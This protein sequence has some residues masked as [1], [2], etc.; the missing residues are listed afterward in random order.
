MTENYDRYLESFRQFADRPVQT[1]SPPTPS[2]FARIHLQSQDTLASFTRTEKLDCLPLS[3]LQ[4]FSF[5]H[6][7]LTIEN[8]LQHWASSRIDGM[9]Y[10]RK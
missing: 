4:V 9:L 10:N 7:D 3:R 5:Y 8:G 2:L 1:S 6:C